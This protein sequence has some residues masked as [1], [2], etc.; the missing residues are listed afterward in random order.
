MCLLVNDARMRSDVDEKGGDSFELVPECL[1]VDVVAGRAAVFWPLV[2]DFVAT[3]CCLAHG[4]LLASRRRRRRLLRSQVRLI[5]LLETP[6]RLGHVRCC[7]TRER[8]R[9]RDAEMRHERPGLELD[10]D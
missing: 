3:P 8:R 7:G 9:T 2:R 6:C 10:Q 5:R 4:R 1:R